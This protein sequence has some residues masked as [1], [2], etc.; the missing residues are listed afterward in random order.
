VNAVWLRLRVEA[1]AHWRAWFGVA[2]LIGVVGGGTI[3]AF[4]AADRTQTAYDRFLRGTRAFDIALTNGSTPDTV[5]RQFDF[6]EIAHLPAVADSSQLSYYD[7]RGKTTAGKPIVDTDVSVFASA[8]GRFGTALNGVRVLHG[9]LPT[10]VNEIALSFF[11]ADRLDVHLVESLTLALAGPAALANRPLAPAPIRVVGLVSIQGGF[12]PLTGGLPPLALLAPAYARTHPDAFQVLALRLRDGTRGI[13]AFNRELDRRASTAQVV[14][15]NQLELR[16]P[17]Q[18]SLDVEATALR[19][20]GFVVAGVALLLVGQALVRLGYV[21]SDEDG[22]L[23]GLGFTNGQLRM[24]AIARGL[25]IGV[26]ATVTAVVTAVLL[27]AL[28]PVGVARNAELHPGIAVNAAYV[29]IGALGVFVGVAFLSVLAALF[30]P[31]SA[32]SRRATA[33]VTAGSRLGGAVSAA[34]ASTA[35]SAGVRMALEPGRGRSSVPVRSTIISAVPG[36][37]VIAGVLGFSASLSRVL[38]EPHLYGWN[39]DIQVGDLFAPNLRP[40]A[41]KLAARPE[42][43]G[44]AVAT[45]TRLRVGSDLFDA[46]A[47]E[48]VKGSLG[49]TV[50][51]GRAPQSASEIMLGTRTLEDLGLRVGDTMRVSL[52]NRSARLRIVGRGV[53]PE[54]SGAARLGEGAAITFAGAQRFADGVVAD[55]VLVRF[56]KGPAGDRQLAALSHTRLGNVYLPGKPSDLVDLSR[57]G[58]LPSVIAGLL[59]I[60]AVGTLAHALFSS[61]RR[62]RRELAIFKV[63]GF[64]RRQVSAAIGW[65]AAVTA[66]LA[67]VIGVPLGIVLGRWSW[68]AFARQLGL[69]DQPVTPLTAILAV[70][71]LAIVVAIVTALIPA[72]VAA[73]TPPAVALRAE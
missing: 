13:P 49:P 59:A 26:G 14:T 70:A 15:S 55:I 50:V 61:A 34:G 38:D 30:V 46:L 62:R 64:R 73:S 43:D 41:E 71:A 8:D 4:A 35:A 18:R 63:L 39:W 68:Q 66:L 56:H 65:Q 51:E 32:R 28:T 11:A 10:H 12:P 21:L 20:L 25:L 37:A 22:V 24:R 7:G 60:M 27:S 53:L 45:I 5:N 44:V 33:S 47:I 58:G 17:V 67:L 54:F 6:D 52:G 16:A 29:G 23:H 9:R 3:A 31:R 19:L 42:T 48:P 36:V 2:L 72:R 57:V 69:P 40:D 1:R